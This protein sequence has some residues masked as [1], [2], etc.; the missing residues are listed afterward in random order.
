MSDPNET[1]FSFLFA[2][3][4]SH[5]ATNAIM[6][7]YETTVLNL[8]LHGLRQ[9]FNRIIEATTPIEFAFTDRMKELLE[10][11]AGQNLKYPYAYIVLNDLDLVK[12]QINTATMAHSGFKSRR[13]EGDSV[14]VSFAF[15]IKFN[16]TLNVVDSDDKRML[17]LAQALLLADVSRAFNFTINANGQQTIVK[18]ARTSNMSF[19]ENMI[20]TDTEQDFATARTTMTFEVQSRMGFTTLVPALKQINVNVYTAAPQG[21]DPILDSTLTIDLAQGLDGQT[22]TEIIYTKTK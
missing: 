16:I 12:D 11:R 4:V 17:S 14:P 1:N 8:T 9:S 15:P 21:Q 2:T 13:L 7:L 6:G 19:P 3:D 10:K 20:N 5:Y 18:V 22:D